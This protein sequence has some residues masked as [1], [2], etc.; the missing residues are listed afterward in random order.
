M[1]ISVYFVYITFGDVVAIG[2]NHEEEKNDYVNTN[3]YVRV[4]NRKNINIPGTTWVQ[5]YHVSRLPRMFR[6]NLLASPPS[7]PRERGNQAGT[8]E[9][10]E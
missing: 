3:I 5:V 8:N 4:L 10:R 7:R 6:P 1:Y 9:E 2:L